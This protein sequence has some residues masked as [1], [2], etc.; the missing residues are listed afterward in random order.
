MQCPVKKTPM[1]VLELEG[2]EIDYCT[3]CG[4]IWL[5]AGELALLL[6]NEEAGRDLLDSLQPAHK[7]SRK[8]RCPVCGKRMKP[9]SAGG[10]TIDRCPHGHGIW[11]DRGELA[12]IIRHGS[13]DPQ[14]RVATFLE[15]MFQ[16]G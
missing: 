15:N 5:D 11:F 2:V 9:V 16:E 1:L 13:L 12:D 3:S 8:L 14:H 4:G 10:I 7:A 6:G